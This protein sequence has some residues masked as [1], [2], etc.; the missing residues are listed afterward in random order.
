VGGIPTQALARFGEEVDLLVVGSRGFG[1][2]RRMLFGSTSE[3]LVRHIRC[4]LLIVRRGVEARGEPTHAT[5]GA[6]GAGA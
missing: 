2:A 1:P 6:S 5:T 4:P 3:Y